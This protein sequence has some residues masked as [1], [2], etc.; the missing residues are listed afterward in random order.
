MG[1]TFRTYWGRGKV[2]TEFRW[3]SLRKRGNLEDILV[4]RNIIL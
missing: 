4:D 3:E 1:G 2:H